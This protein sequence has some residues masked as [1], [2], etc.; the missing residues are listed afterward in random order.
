MSITSVMPSNHL[1]FCHLLLPHSIFPSQ[2]QG[3]FQWV[4]SLHQVAKVLELQLQHQSFQRIFR[5]DFRTGWISLQSKGLSRVFSNTTADLSNIRFLSS[6][7]TSKFFSLTVPKMGCDL[8][9][10]WIFSVMPLSFSWSYSWTIG[11]FYNW[12][13][14]RI[15]GLPVYASKVFLLLPVGFRHFTVMNSNRNSTLSSN[16]EA[17]PVSHPWSQ[18]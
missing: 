14:F 11:A 9:L 2:Y 15:Q 7:D 3:L 13:P 10:M 8:Q 18:H 4:S 16:G 5:T 1:I 6:Q 17:G 12:W